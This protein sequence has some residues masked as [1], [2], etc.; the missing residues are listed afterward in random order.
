MAISL[1]HSFQSAK[2]D[3]ADNTIVQ[4]SDWNDE[5][6][7]TQA[8]GRLLGR[9]SAGTGA[10]EE[11]TP[12]AGLTMSAGSLTA[13]VTSVAGK[14]GAVTLAN[15]DVSG[16]APLASP[17]LTGTPTA[18]T[19]AVGTNTTQIATTA[20]VGAEIANDA[21][22]KT[23]GGASGTW[24]ISITGSSA[25]TTGNAATAT[26]LATAR[27][28]ALS[29]AATGTATSF[30][31]SAN[32]TV[33]V[34]GL[35]A[36]NLNA[37]TVPDARLSGTYSGVTLK[38]DGANTVFTTPSAGST[39]AQGR[40]VF[41]LAE[42]RSS[43][44]SQVGAIVFY[45]PN[46][47]SS[48]MHQLEVAGL[49]Y[50]QNMVRFVVQGYR[51]TAAW[52]DVRKTTFGTVD[53][54]VRWGVDPSGKNCLI[55]GDVGTTWA[56]PHFSIIRALFS[57]SGLTDAYCSG[58]TVGIVT[59]LSTFT[60]VTSVIADSPLASDLS[61]NATTATTLATGRTIGMTG[62]VTYT[63]GSF[64]G[65][66]NV[67][68]TAT[69]ANSGVTA[70]T[71]NFATVTVD[72]KGRVTAASSGS[73][74]AF[75]AGT[76]MLFVQTAAP[77]GWTKSTT[78]NNKALRIVSG[79]ASSGG[80]VAFTTAF[81]SKAVSGTIANATAGGSISATTL[82]TSQIPSHTHGVTAQFAN[83]GYS[84]TTVSWFYAPY[85]GS[86]TTVTSGGA[87]SGGSHTHTFTGT[88][89][90]HTFTGTAIDLAVQYVDA[91]I[92]SKD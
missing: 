56:Y 23:G 44:A 8:T 41:G 71:Y 77:T 4:P 45:A 92:A 74:E 7:L 54:D 64:N 35:N 16:S 57:H 75:P 88:A 60:N 11:I 84:P 62:D 40:T 37:G 76:L 65:S 39:N 90:N 69:L 80:T 33:P 79:T 32:I 42:Y 81:A 30:D 91:I 25:S 49:L 53:V 29:G 72:A 2:A 48:I 12:G 52:N 47:N 59:D 20:F 36:T 46:T 27:T 21:P 1:K 89:H 38:I 68:G 83:S 6:V 55:L 34:T 15:A 9:T 66:A 85:T 3:G 87:G 82:T 17:A 5:H 51:T 43:A 10:T 67:T 86:S 61:G 18:P 24:G 13:N 58:W 50:N 31:G 73:V 63:S 14:T 19:A 22:T 78:H 70:G 26:A 28:I